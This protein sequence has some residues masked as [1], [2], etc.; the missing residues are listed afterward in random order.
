MKSGFQHVNTLPYTSPNGASWPKVWC[1]MVL[2]KMRCSLWLLK[3]NRIPTN[4]LR[5]LQHL[6]DSLWCDGRGHSKESALHAVRDYMW[7]R[8]VW[9]TFIDLDY[10][11]T[12]FRQNLEDW[13]NSNV[14]NKES[15]TRKTRRHA[16]LSLLLG[17]YGVLRT[18]R[19]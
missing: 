1:M 7:A 4:E 10:W 6:T 14:F 19:R 12:F 17:V 9:K 11:V 16:S 18:R 3:W 5:Y 15:K 2:Q 8:E 13:L